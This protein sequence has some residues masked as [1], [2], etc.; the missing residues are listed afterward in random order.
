MRERCLSPDSMVYRAKAVSSNPEHLRVNRLAWCCSE[1]ELQHTTQGT[2]ACAE[3]WRHLQSKL[4]KLRQQHLTRKRSAYGFRRQVKE[5]ARTRHHRT[6]ARLCQRQ[7][8]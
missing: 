6:D 2:T 4:P 1:K 5:Q 3:H 7:E 8:S